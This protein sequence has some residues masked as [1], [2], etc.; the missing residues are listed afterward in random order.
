MET[1]LVSQ[2]D[3]PLLVSLY[4][5]GFADAPW[6]EAQIA[7]SLAAPSVWALLV[8]EGGTP[9]GFI[10]CQQVLDEAEILTLCVVPSAR[11]KG[12][13]HSLVQAAL[14]QVREKGGCRMFLEVAADNEPACALYEKTGFR[15]T[16][17]RVGYYK[18]PKGTVDALTMSL[19]AV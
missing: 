13:G 6:S 14:S 2:N 15:V 16:G 9:C 3:L 5:E 12:L 17:K 11:R 4:A 7:G 10:L 18:R 1:R 8:S 19:D